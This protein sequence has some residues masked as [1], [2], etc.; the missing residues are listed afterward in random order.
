MSLPASVNPVLRDEL[1]CIADSNWMLGHWYINCL[2][3]GRELTDFTSMA[4]IAEDKLGHTR[5]LFRFMEEHYD[6]PEHQLEFARPVDQIHGMALL[7][8]PPRNWADFVLTTYLADKALWRFSD[9]LRTGGF[10]PVAN[11][12]TKFGEEAYFHQLCIDG[13]LK[14]LDETERDDLAA[15]LPERLPALYRWFDNAG[16][17]RLLEAGVRTE[18]LPRARERLEED[19]D[20]TTMAILGRKTTRRERSAPGAVS[21]AWDERRRR[22]RGSIM[23]PRLWESMVPTSAAARLA[24]RPLAVSADDNIDLFGPVKKDETE[25]RF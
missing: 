3:N 13:W 2:L 10:A 16:S 5:A 15:A 18:P 24:R 22:I 7:D 11:L 8:A 12:V 19:V 17:D 1:L 6:L 23:P 4:G 9:T 20:K 21:G 25:P 14:A